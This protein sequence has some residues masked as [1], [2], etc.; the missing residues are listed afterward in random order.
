MKST[1]KIKVELECT[2]AQLNLIQHALDVYSRLGSGQIEELENHW[3]INEFQI[4]KHTIEGATNYADYHEEK[5]NLRQ[6]INAYKNLLFMMAPNASYGIHADAISD[7]C[8]QSWDMIQVIRHEV[9]KQDP[10]RTNFGVNA[11]PASRSSEKEELIT[12]NITLDACT[13]SK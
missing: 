9:W 5:D 11:Y 13:N 2:A 1:Q 6:F 3:G 12:V 8:R 10:E 7:T 4:N